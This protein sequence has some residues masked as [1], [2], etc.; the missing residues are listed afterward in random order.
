MLALS[1][2]VPS[3]GFCFRCSNWPLSA[4][5][6]LLANHL[7][8]HGLSWVKHF[9]ATLGVVGGGVQFTSLLMLDFPSIQS[10]LDSSSEVL[11]SVLWTKHQG[12]IICRGK[13]VS[14]ITVQQVA[15]PTWPVHPCNPRNEAGS[16]S[17]QGTR[18]SYKTHL[19]LME[20][21]CGELIGRRQGVC[22]G[23]FSC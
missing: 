1:S 17:S 20:I 19:T 9:L 21:H 14:V 16:V 15:C 12:H 7:E 4:H 8:R 3:K 6:T 23:P 18:N 22:Y 13:S 5:S 10:R 2:S 11:S